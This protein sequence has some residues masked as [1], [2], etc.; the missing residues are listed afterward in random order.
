[1]STLDLTR[2]I[3]EA[4]GSTIK[5]AW[6]FL[7]VVVAIKLIPILLKRLHEDRLRKKL[8]TLDMP[9]IDCLTG[10]DFEWLLREVYSSRGAKCLLT[11]YCGDWGADLVLEQ[12]GVKTVVQAKRYKKAVGI[13]A[14][15]EAVA[16]KAKYGA[17]EAVVVTN[18]TFTKSAVELARVNRVRLRG[19]TEL[20][21]M[22]SEMKGGERK[23]A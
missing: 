17:S 21:K 11:P 12:N 15:Q 14:V 7:L 23:A 10:K 9:E 18:S 20:E 6:P 3:L 1:M 22:I 4:V 13:R 8:R 19:R 16:A 2:P 5:W